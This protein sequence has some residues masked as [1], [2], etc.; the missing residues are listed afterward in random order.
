MK[1]TRTDRLQEES[2]LP[3]LCLPKDYSPVDEAEVVA[4]RT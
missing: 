3:G 2:Q 1:S 4:E